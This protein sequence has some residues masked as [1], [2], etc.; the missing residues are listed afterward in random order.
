MEIIRESNLEEVAHG[1]WERQA[2]KDNRA[3]LVLAEINAGA[4]PYEL[5]RREYSF[6]APPENSIVSIARLN[7]DDVGALIMRKDT[8]N[9][10]NDWAKERGLVPEPFTQILSGLATWA[11]SCRYFIECDKN[12]TQLKKYREWR[13]RPKPALMGV[14]IDSERCSIKK[15]GLDQYEI[16]DG[17]GRLLPF[18][19]LLHE[20]YEFHPVEAFLSLPQFD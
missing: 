18:E 2:T 14:I 4:N 15:I 10:N 6:K 20:G 1:F 16:I 5:L 12:D 19:A 11:R 17:Y 3:R 8:V 9:G 7:R 13:Q